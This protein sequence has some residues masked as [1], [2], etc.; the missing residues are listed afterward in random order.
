METIIQQITL[1]LV[2]KI[3]KKAF[4]EELSDLDNLAA[5]LFE[6]C[7]EYARLML[8]EIIR[9]R[10]LQLREDKQFRK[11][12]GL[13][14]KEKDRPRQLL[15][16]LGMI[17]WERDYYYDKTKARY[18]TPLD[19]MLGIRGYE[20]IGDEVSAQLLKR[21]TEVSY[22]KSSDIV[23]GGVVSRQSIHNHILKTDVPEKQ[24]KINKKA[25][26][27]LHIYAD[28]DHVHM[29]KEGKE[30]GKKNQIVPLVTV[31]EGIKAV[32]SRRNRT[33]EAV[34]FVDEEQS[35]K[36]LWKSVEGYIAKAYDVEEIEKIYIHGDGGK[37]IQ[38]GLETFANVVH[39]MDGY[40]FF[41]SLKEISKK[42]SK[43]NLKVVILNA[44]AKDDRI[45]A[46]KLIKGLAGDG[47]DILKFGRYLLG[48]WES[49]R[50]LIL[51]DIPGSCTEGQVSHV[52]SERFSRNPMGWSKEGLG[53]LSKLRVYRINGGKLSGKELKKKVAESYSEYAERFISER[54]EGATDWS[55]FEIDKPI[56]NGSF[57]TQAL[58]RAYGANHGV[59][60]RN[61]LS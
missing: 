40:H 28:E 34:H 58:I 32:G 45:K 35:P 19:H 8:Q 27:K 5:E 53:K 30:R 61:I 9:V 26:K 37:W 33:I 44:I 12:E 16:K 47:E 22:A 50:N 29:Q 49:I 6:D 15:T 18:V 46:D 17:Y 20:R 7:A 24:P 13:V 2:E 55:I 60:G 23:T 42:C 3:N 11:E 41:K 56:M 59:L 52:L 51:L 4:S 1:K 38:N 57:G 43:S 25:V 36:K 54:I 39:V 21:A 14:L 48:N 31:T 10:N